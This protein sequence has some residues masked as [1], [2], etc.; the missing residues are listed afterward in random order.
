MNFHL[1]LVPEFTDFNAVSV[2]T[3]NFK[4]DDGQ[5]VLLFVEAILAKIRIEVAHATSLAA[6]FGFLNELFTIE[7]LASFDSHR[8]TP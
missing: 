7:L 3:G 1:S 5:T 8:N 6:F 4:G 2:G